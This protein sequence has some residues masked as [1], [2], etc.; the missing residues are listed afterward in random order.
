ME[1]RQNHWLLWQSVSNPVIC[2][3]VALKRLQKAQ[4]QSGGPVHRLQLVP[5]FCF[6]YFWC[7]F[8]SV[9]NS[10]TTWAPKSSTPAHLCVRQTLATLYF[11]MPAWCLPENRLQSNS[12]EKHL[13]TTLPP[14]LQTSSPRTPSCRE[15]GGVWMSGWPVSPAV[16]MMMDAG[17][18]M[19]VNNSDPL[20]FHSTLISLLN[21]SDHLRLPHP[22]FSPLGLLHR[23]QKKSLNEGKC[24]AFTTSYQGLGLICSRRKVTELLHIASEKAFLQTSVVFLSAWKRQTAAWTRERA[25]VRLSNQW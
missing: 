5:E 4:T 16:T 13:R 18:L 7:L 24:S 14:Q 12:E 2:H 1:H 10:L 3:I 20:Q 23:Y 22:S 11:K 6:R 17:L 25:D 21:L 15:R 9:S 19:P 8:C